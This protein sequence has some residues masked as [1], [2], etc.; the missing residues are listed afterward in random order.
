MHFTQT[1]FLSVLRICSVFAATNT[2]TSTP[3]THVVRVGSTNNSIKYFPDKISAQVGDIIQFQFAGGNH[4][5]TQSTFDAPCVP[6]SQ[7]TNNTGVFSGFMNVAASLNS[8]GMVPVFSMPVKV[9]T[10]MWFYCSQAKHCQKGMVLVVNEN[11]K[12]NASRSLSNFASLAAK[13]PANLFPTLNGTSA[14]A[15]T[16]STSSTSGT[17]STSESN[18][19][20]SSGSS[21]DS[22]D[23]SSSNSDSDSSST[24][25]STATTPSPS[26]SSTS[27]GTSSNNNEDSSFS[28]SGSSSSP[29]TLS[30]TSSALASATA[31][32]AS[33][34]IH[35]RINLFGVFAVSGVGMWGLL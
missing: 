26:V 4:T 21:S 13:A 16:S 20:S 18:S 15:S 25:D 27:S 31:N 9:A 34:I 5:V 11:T 10:P 1:L 22:S 24:T 6:I 7:S 2:T 33:G 29:S 19:G 14:T 12:I 30:T 32:T 28:P 3:Q 17:S 8:T 23:S 35:S